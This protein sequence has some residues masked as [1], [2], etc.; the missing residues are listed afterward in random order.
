MTRTYGEGTIYQSRRTGRWHVQVSSGTGAN[1]QRISHTYATESDA[2]AGL[3]VFRETGEWPNN[4]LR[5]QAPPKRVP[6]GSAFSRAKAVELVLAEARAQGWPDAK[7]A[8]VLTLQLGITRLLANIFGPCVYCGTWEAGQIDHVI[9]KVRGGTDDPR[10]LV[11][12]CRP[13]NYSKG[14]KMLSEW[15]RSRVA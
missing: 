2:I 1:R 15:R 14:D 13:C 3:Q 9:P 6:K 5:R 11:S 12:A 4:G 10:N 8:R 7:L